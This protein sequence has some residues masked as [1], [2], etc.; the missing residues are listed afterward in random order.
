MIAERGGIGVRHGC[1]CVNMYIKRLLGVG[2]AKNTMAHIGLMLAPRLMEKLLLGLVRVSFGI[3]NDEAEVDRLVQTIEQIAA[4]PASLFNR[5]L[6]AQHFGTPFLPDTATG[7][8]IRD[9][10]EETTARV[11]RTG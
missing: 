9:S 5:L 10:V 8:K 2:R 1:F 4:E 3:A 7:R 6:A 11:Y